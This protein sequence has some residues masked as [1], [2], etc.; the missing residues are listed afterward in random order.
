M[1]QQ[2]ERIIYKPG[3]IAELLECST[4]HVYR[5]IRAGKMP[6]KRLGRRIVIP[7]QLFHEWLNK[8]DEWES[9]DVA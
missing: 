8:S 6:H 1:N 5:L 2:Q 4:E 3:D 9:A 7:A